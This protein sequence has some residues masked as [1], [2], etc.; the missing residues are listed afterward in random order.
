MDFDNQNEYNLPDRSSAYGRRYLMASN[1]SIIKKE[2]KIE[3]MTIKVI[4]RNIS[5]AKLVEQGVI[6]E[7]DAEMDKRARE[8]VSIAK[9]QAK[10]CNKPI[11]MYDKETKKPYLVTASG[12][13]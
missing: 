1:S 4:K 3:D 7:Q 8:A 11:A 12:R 9:R 13:K 10:V 5:T 6:S 2:I